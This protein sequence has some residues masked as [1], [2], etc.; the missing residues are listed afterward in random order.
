MTGGVRLYA[1]S[2]EGLFIWRSNAGGWEEVNRGLATPFLWAFAGCRHSP[3]RVYAAVSEDGLYRTDDAGKHWTKV[4]EHDVRAVAIDPTDDDVVYAGTQPVHLYR[5]EDRGAT[6]EELSRLTQLP[7]EVRERWR[8]P[9]PPDQGHVLNIFIHPDDPRIIYLCIEHGGVHRS[10]DRG[11]TWE[12]V[13][14]GLLGYPDMHMISSLPHRFDRY[15]VSS[16]RGFFTSDEPG[17]GWVRAENGFTRNY[18]H[19][20]VWLPPRGEGDNPVMLIATADESPGYW[21]RPKHADSV[22]H[23]SE[24]CG[25][26]WHPVGEG[27]PQPIDEGLWGFVNHPLAEGGA[28]LGLGRIYFREH[29]REC[30]PGR[31]FVTT[32]RG[33]SWEQLPVEV[34]A[35][36]ALYAAAD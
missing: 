16:A 29:A 13:S 10:L 1:G 19:D 7:P 35:V 33:D 22:V 30:G 12:D 18:F 25:E 4:L 26:S 20:Y 32:D 14:E 23:R 24:D 28:F 31:I 5:S 8:F 27:L 21:D 11:E 3:E 34:P 2:S 9:V 15:Y 36:R 6:W 17:R